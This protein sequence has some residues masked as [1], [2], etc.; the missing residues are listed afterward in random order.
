[1]QGSLLY[2]TSRIKAQENNLI[3]DE[4]LTRM[5]DSQSYEDA[6]KILLECNYGEGMALNSFSDYDDLLNAEK[7][8][9]T[10]LIREIAPKNSGMEVFLVKNDYHNAK[11]V[12]KGLELG[13]ENI[14]EFKFMLAP[15]GLIG[16]EEILNSI[17]ARNFTT[18]PKHMA[19]ACKM[20]T[21]EGTGSAITPRYIDTVMDKAC[22][23]D[24]S[25][26]IKK[27]KCKEIKEYVEASVDLINLSALLRCKM[28]DIGIKIFKESLLEGGTFSP[29][30]FVSLYEASLETISEKFRY[31]SFGKAA[32]IGC[33]GAAKKNLAVFES[34]CDNLLLEIFKKEKNNIFSVATIAGFYLAK[35]T[36]I[37]VARIII[38]CLKNKVEK[39]TI[40]QRLRELYV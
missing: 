17:A 7:N 13:Y 6:V 18:L 40:K 5:I 29:D 8:A 15:D 24:I 28:K 31:T 32:S 38:V 26:R 25:E 35:L 37:K 20:L 33:E 1:M 2:A 3:T 36:E 12:I 39:E 9:V 30:Y 16:A 11:A 22:Y 4:R 14:N 34:Q 10:N 19:N 21:I 27:C 23:K